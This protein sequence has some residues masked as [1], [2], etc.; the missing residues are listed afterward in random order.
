MLIIFIEILYI[1]LYN[2]TRNSSHLIFMWDITEK[3][4]HL[5]IFYTSKNFGLPSQQ[6]VDCPIFKEILEALK[7]LLD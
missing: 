3:I 1:T 4:N 2:G 7:I 6:L 5:P